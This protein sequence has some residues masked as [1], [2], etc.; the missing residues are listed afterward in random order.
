MLRGILDFLHLLGI[1]AVLAVI[2]L[3]AKAV[4]SSC[5]PRE[6]DH[7]KECRVY[8]YCITGPRHHSH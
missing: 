8:P 6:V 5:H 1:L 7:A 4:E 2:A 3:L